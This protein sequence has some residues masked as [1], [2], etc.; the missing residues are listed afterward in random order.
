MPRVENCGENVGDW[1]EETGEGSSTYDV[2]RSCAADLSKNPH[3]YDNK[4][5]PY[6]WAGEPAGT[7][8]W[9]N[10]GCEHPDYADE[11]YHCAVCDK[12]L[13]ARDN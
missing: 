9:A 3:R 1:C 7:D 11:D 5:K 2:C 4:L 12:R 8:G 10:D 13:T 6:G